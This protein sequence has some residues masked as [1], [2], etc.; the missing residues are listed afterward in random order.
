MTEESYDVLIVGGGT[1]GITAAAQLMAQEV[2]PKRIGIV[3][4]AH[5]HFYQPLWT[6]VG[7][8]VFPREVS[9]RSMADVVP[10][11]TEW[12]ADRVASFEPDQNR[13]TTEDRRTLRYEQLIVAPGIQL[14]WQTIEGL[15]EALGKGGVTSNYSYDIVPYTWDCI[16]SFEGGNAVFT[17]PNTPIKCAGAPQKIMWL[18]EEA[19]RKQGVR[20]KATI[21]YAAAGGGIFGIPKYKAALEKLVAARDIQTDYRKNLVAL[22]PQ[23]KE[24]VF[25]DLDGGEELVLSYDMIHVTPPQSAPDFI[26]RSPLANEAG[27]VDVDKH[28]LQHTQYRNVFSLGDASSLPCSKTGAAIRKQAP[29]LVENLMALRTGKPLAARYDGYA[30]CPLVTGY[31][32]VMLAEFGYDGVIMETFPFDQARERYSMYALKAHALPALYWNGMLR[33]RM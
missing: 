24:A 19:F 27:W 32:K 21:T 9:M 29:V 6:L 7:A 13:L 8:G 16:R 22:R 25:A 28:T 5:H 2:P 23:S 15:P 10:T 12:I 17:F 1:G 18:A 33:G 11:G 26:K 20:Q 3:D 14:D 30:S 31:G 4:P